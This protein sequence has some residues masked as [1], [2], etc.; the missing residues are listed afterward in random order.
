MIY[1]FTLIL[2]VFNS[3]LL[4]A[5]P[6]LEITP[7]D[8]EFEDIFH[9]NKNVLFINTGDDSLR[10]D[11]LVYRNYYFFLRFNKPWEYP[12][13]LQQNDTVK[14]DCILESHIYVPAADTTDTLFIYSNGLKPLEKLKVKINIMMMI[15]EWAI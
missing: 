14:M 12:V 8:I 7:D 2:L 9:R 3:I 6:R 4:I 15:M 11:S 5:Q 13:L 10:I 1:K